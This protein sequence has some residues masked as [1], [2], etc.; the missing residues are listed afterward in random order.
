MLFCEYIYGCFI[1]FCEEW[2][3]CFDKESVVS[4]IAFGNTA[5]YTQGTAVL[6]ETSLLPFPS[7]LAGLMSVLTLRAKKP[8]QGIHGS[9]KVRGGY[10]SF[11]MAV[12]CLRCSMFAQDTLLNTERNLMIS[13]RF[14]TLRFNFIK[15]K[16]P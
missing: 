16:V 6:L 9:T 2:Y 1:H 8:A 5:K 12:L 4:K 13:H 10:V 7:S 15:R 11:L 14:A 3:E